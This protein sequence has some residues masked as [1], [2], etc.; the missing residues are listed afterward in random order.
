MDGN[1]KR[2]TSLATDVILDLQYRISPPDSDNDKWCL[3]A[4]V[5]HVPHRRVEM[6]LKKSQVLPKHVKIIQG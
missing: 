4:L 3:G 1:Q 2:G 5:L 6:L